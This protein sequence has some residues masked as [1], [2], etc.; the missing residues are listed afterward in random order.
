MKSNLAAFKFVAS[1]FLL[2]SVL[3][4]HP[5][6]LQY[7]KQTGKITLAQSKS[8]VVRV[9]SLDDDLSSVDDQTQAYSI[10]T[11]NL[12]GERHCA[13]KWMTTTLQDCFGDQVEVVNRYTRWKHW[14]QYDDRDTE[15]SRNHHDPKSSLVIAMF[16]DPYDWL[17]SMRLKPYHSP[18]HFDQKWKKFV[19]TPWTMARGNGDQQLIESGSQSN[20]TCM[21]RFSFNEVV[22]CS[23][24][25]RNMY[26]RTYHGKTVGVNYELKHDGSGE[27]Y[28]S[29]IDLRRDKIKNFL[30]VAKFN[31]VASFLPVQ[32]E[33][34]VSRGTGELIDE[35]ENMTGLHAHC[36]RAPPRPLK[37]KEIDAEFIKWI[38]ANVDWEVEKLVGYAPR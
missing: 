30:S 21:H 33:F 32:F 19:T 29:I 31:G 10:K 5:L 16:R 3:F 12:I 17:E 36:K 35:I 6:I 20:A 15:K 11:I 18:N 24:L 8:K 25:D 28:D 7:I 1:G 34:V 4:N 9:R 2:A 38:T 27:P 37:R 23:P 13:T 22:P 26:N 14:F